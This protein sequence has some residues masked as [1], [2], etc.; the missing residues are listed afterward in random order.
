MTTPTRRGTQ[1]AR[2]SIR[3]IPEQPTA[4][5][6]PLV[7]HVSPTARRA[8]IQATGSICPGTEREHWMSDKHLV[9]FWPNLKL[10][11]LWADFMTSS[12]KSQD[13]WCGLRPAAE[14]LPDDHY[15]ID[16]RGYKAAGRICLPR[17]VE[18]WAPCR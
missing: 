16:S 11:R 2:S 5:V 8:A 1:K 6:Q 17:L 14:A 15:E 4:C 13:I 12:H 9:Y 7:Y 3:R 18:V 10:A